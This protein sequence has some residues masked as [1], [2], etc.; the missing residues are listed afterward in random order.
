MN[1]PEIDPGSHDLP[2]D[3]AAADEQTEI[4][5]PVQPAGKGRRDPSYP[6]IGQA[7]KLLLLLFLLQVLLTLPIAALR[8]ALHPAATAVVS[9]SSTAIIIA[10][11]VKRTGSAV[12]RSAAAR[13]RPR[14][15]CW[16]R[17]L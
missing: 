11:G 4:E 14:R 13:R 16:R 2:P 3:A 10:W 7:I 12:P 17:W 6:G 1:K 9:L 15:R 5:N 8:P